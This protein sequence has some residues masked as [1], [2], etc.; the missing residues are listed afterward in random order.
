ML[1]GTSNDQNENYSFLCEKENI[2]TPQTLFAFQ[3]SL[4]PLKQLGLKKHKPLQLYD[5]KIYV[6]AV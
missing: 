3:T 6:Q 4:Y 1:N 5:C 2:H